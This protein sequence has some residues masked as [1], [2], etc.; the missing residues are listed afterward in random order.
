LLGDDEEELDDRDEEEG[1][2]IPCAVLEKLL[3]EDK[4]NGKILS[5]FG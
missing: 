2:G 5:S 1:D 4:G 3:L